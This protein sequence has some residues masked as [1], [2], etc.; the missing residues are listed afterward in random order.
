MTPAVLFFIYLGR[1]DEKEGVTRRNVRRG[2][3]SDEGER[4]TRSDEE[5]ATKSD[6]EG[7]MRLR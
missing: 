5:G 3:K 2:R 6:E 4:A 7:A 1:S